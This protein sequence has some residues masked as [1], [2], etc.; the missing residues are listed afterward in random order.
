[1]KSLLRPYRITHRKPPFAAAGALLLGCV[2]IS[3]SAAAQ[4]GGIAHVPNLPALLRSSAQGYMGVLT[5]DVDGEAAT[6]LKLRDT[7]GAVITLLDHDAPAAQA[8]IRV[9]DVVLEINGQKI[10]TSEQFSRLLRELPAGRTLSLVVSR[11]GLVQTVKVQLVDRKKMEHDVWNKLES[12]R[13]G[14]GSAPAMGIL[15]GGSGDIPSGG[16]HMPFFGNT[17]N[18]GALVEPLTAQMTE[19]LGIQSGLMVKQVAH[20]SQADAAGLKPFDI[21]LKVGGDTI[22]TSADWDRTLRANRD[23][24]V[25]VVVLRDRRQQTLTLQVDSHHR[26]SSREQPPAADAPLL[27]A[28]AAPAPATAVTP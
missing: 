6:R 14:S 10:E 15:S 25:P 26:R 22:S 20:K 5:G 4:A 21:I 11:D 12:D 2:F 19:Y 8:G 7:H 13:E 18:V 27:A 24:A 3:L 9:N 16:F 17:L 1:M 23:K 28:A